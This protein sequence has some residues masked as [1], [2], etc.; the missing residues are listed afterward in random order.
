[1]ARECFGGGSPI[2][3]SPLYD[4]QMLAGRVRPYN[5]AL[6]NKLLRYAREHLMCMK[7]KDKFREY[8]EFCL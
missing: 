1:M 3:K 2:C 6:Q 8:T 7:I 4:L 5:D